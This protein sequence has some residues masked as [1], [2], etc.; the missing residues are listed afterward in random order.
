MAARRIQAGFTL[1][2]A[3]VSLVILGIL[4]GMV[5]VFIRAPV[6]AY[7]DTAR[8][9]A[10]TE[11]ADGAIRRI[12]RDIQ[13]ALPNS[14]R[15]PAD[16]ST[17]CFEFLPVLG[18]G[19]YRVERDGSNSATDDVLDFSLADNGFDVLA[20]IGLDTLSGTNHVVVY[21]LGIPG[22][23]AYNSPAQNRAQIQ[24][25]NFPAPG[26]AT[27]RIAL[28]GTFQ[29]PFESP[30]RRFQVIGNESVVYTCAGNS[31]WRSTRALGSAAL[32][33]CPAAGGAELVGNVDCTQSFFN[34]APANAT[35]QGMVEIRLTMSALT[36][37]GVESI[38]LYDR[39]SVNN[40]P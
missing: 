26:G 20:Q 19:R 40:A 27:A 39:V 21:N 1:L 16:G 31:I 34:Y 11:A 8:R 22:A 23:S 28:N 32:A 5:A 37:T 6:D 12:G 4:A 33:S 13:S 24:S 38:R 36:P 14:F 15:P 17:A 7:V 30:S 25:V 3:I 2:E 29:F 10:L 18:S 9:A 35:R